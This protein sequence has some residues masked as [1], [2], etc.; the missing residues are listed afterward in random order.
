MRPLPCRLQ[1]KPLQTDRFLHLLECNSQVPESPHELRCPTSQ[2]SPNHLRYC[3]DCQRELEHSGSKWYPA[4]I[5]L[6]DLEAYQTLSRH[7]LCST[8]GLQ[9]LHVCRP[10]HH[11][12]LHERHSILLAEPRRIG[13]NRQVPIEQA[14][15]CAMYLATQRNYA[16]PVQMSSVPLVLYHPRRSRLTPRNPFTKHVAKCCSLEPV[17]YL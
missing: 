15:R 3:L 5:M 8:V 2:L 11:L 12:R 13:A 10:S 6:I 14:Q 9:L 7:C 1:L 4:F 16:K 17:V